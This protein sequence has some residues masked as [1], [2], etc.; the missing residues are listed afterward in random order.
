MQVSGR[1][2]LL[3]ALA[4][5][6]LNADTAR[7]FG[8]QTQEPRT[9]EK[10]DEQEAVGGQGTSGA[11]GEDEV[12]TP[13][14][15]LTFPTQRPPL[16]F[17]CAT[18]AET[19]QKLEA[20]P[21][22]R[23]VTE[24]ELAVPWGAKGLRLR[25]LV[26]WARLGG[27]MRSRLGTHVRCS[28][29]DERRLLRHMVRG[30]PLRELPRRRR[31]AW[32]A[33]CL[34]LWDATREMR[35][36]Q[37]DVAWLEQ[38]LLRERGAHGLHLVRLERPPRPV[39]L[40]GV[41]PG[42]PVLAV[43]AMGQYSGN[44]ATQAAWAAFARLLHWRGYPRQALMPCPRRM[45]QPA[46]VKAWPSV[47]WD[48]ISRLPRHGS[49]SPAAAD[50]GLA[51][52][53]SLL[54]L[55]APAS[56][57]GTALLR[58]ARLQLPRADVGTEW[59]A[60]HHADCWASSDCFGLRADRQRGRLDAMA[61]VAGPPPP[62]AQ[63]I[64]ALIRQDHT[65]TLSPAVAWEAELRLLTVE[66]GDVAAAFIA[67]IERVNNALRGMV[68]AQSQPSAVTRVSD[69]PEWIG[70]MASRLPDG[71]ARLPT[72]AAAL[73][74]SLALAH[75][76]CRPEH[77]TLPTWSDPAAYEE[78]TRT[79]PALS[80]AAR[81]LRVD[82]VG[83]LHYGSVAVSPFAVPPQGNTLGVAHLHAA[84]GPL[85]VTLPEGS[86]HRFQLG[87]TLHPGAIISDL[88]KPGSIEI[89]ST[90]QRLVIESIPRPPWAQKMWQ[91]RF[92]TAA[93]FSISGVPFVMRWIP[94]GRFLM[95]S[96]EDET[97]RFDTEGP[98]HEVTLTR[99]YWLGET[100][101]TQAQW[102]AVVQAAGADP[103]WFQKLLGKKGEMEPEP[104]HFRGDDLPVEQVDWQQ[105]SVFCR[106]LSRLL[107]AS[108]PA[109]LQFRLP[110]E[111]EWEY[112]CRAGTTGAFNDGSA[113]TAPQGKDP[114][115]EGL[116]WFDANSDGRTHAVKGKPPNSWGLCD[117]HG[118]VWEWCADGF[119]AYT[120]DAESDPFVSPKSEARRVV[121]GGSW[122]DL[123][124]LCRSACRDGFD[125]GIR[126]D[127]LGLRLAAGQELRAAEPQ[128]R[129][130]FGGPA[131][132]SRRG[133]GRS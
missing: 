83:G 3:A 20:P 49:Q 112:A 42:S 47:T 101:V 9:P 111:A 129:S 113:C 97:G 82:V 41:A 74:R 130:A 110:S 38:R 85:H 11:G 102:R 72:V 119:T 36:F 99:G 59:Q 76:V 67:F 115:L 21:I 84:V 79:L 22:G 34:V 108:L 55:L 93:E 7:A 37:P 78:E 35:P 109:G 123:A 114:A 13:P 66:G 17:L 45:W 127:S 91:D 18:Q 16:T 57:I 29:V 69:L 44:G 53:D 96:P 70:S 4:A 128:A 19:L 2:D 88:T 87:E 27:W 61:A 94:P 133:A 105:S 50:F 63:R 103:S 39:D 92:G 1:A 106:L 10:E 122:D 58:S 116:G 26:R 40:A 90:H 6:R 28:R 46:L 77:V 14:P 60:W 33:E 54:D 86:R 117:M 64:A 24:G 73:G 30:E 80:S 8:F 120:G 52:A 51:H 68:A 107:Q 89:R 23:A 62:W 124:R 75:A 104:S 100:P 48:G 43:S 56:R 71:V 32:A 25:P 31:Q 98:Q 95:G 118:N 65:A 126:W 125:P 5:G 132:R 12:E 81:L 131:R 15:P 121:R